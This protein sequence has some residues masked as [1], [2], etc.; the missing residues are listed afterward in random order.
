MKTNRMKN[1]LFILLLANVLFAQA[2]DFLTTPGSNPRLFSAENT[3]KLSIRYDSLIFNFDTLGLP[4]IDDFSSDHLPKAFNELDF[5]AAKDSTYFRYYIGASPIQDSL[6]YSLDSTF[7]YQ[8]GTTG[9]TISIQTTNVIFLSENDFNQYPPTSKFTTAFQPYTVF[10]TIGGGS[11]TVFINTIIRQ[12]SITFF[13]FPV[14]TNA[15]YIDRKAYLNQSFSQQAPTIGMITFDGLNEFGEPYLTDINQTQ[16]ADFLTSVPIDLG[17]ISNP[18][19]VYFSFFYQAKGIAIDGPEKGDS[20]VLEFYNPDTRRWAKAWATDYVDS[21]GQVD[22]FLYAIVP[23][24]PAFQ[25]KGFQFR[26]KAYAQVSGAYDNWHVD[27]IYL[28]ENRDSID[29]IANDLGYIGPP[30]RLLKDYSVMPWWHFKSNPSGYQADSVFTRIRNFRNQNLNVYYRLRLLDTAANSNYLVT[31]GSN[32]FLGIQNL[33][34]L[35]LGY[36][37]DYDYIPDSI[38]GAGRLDAIYNLDLRPSPT[39]P[40]QLVTSNDTIKTGIELQN[41]Y[42]YDDGTAEA[43][44]GINAVLGSEGYVSY[45]SQKFEIPFPD[46]I[47]GVFIYFLPNNPDIRNQKF[48]VMVWNNLN[49]GSIIYEQPVTSDPIFTPMNGFVPYMLDSNIEVNQIFYIGIKAI[50]QNSMHIGYD[51]NFNNRDKINWS[52]DGNNWN[53]P[54]SRI[55]DG[56]LM[57]RPIFRKKRF[58]VGIDENKL[59]NRVNRLDIYPNPAHDVA[60]LNVNKERRIKEINIYDISSRLVK[61]LLERYVLNTSEFEGGI[62]FINVTLDNGEILT[63]KLLITK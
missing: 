43:G 1:C 39:D 28:D 38:N 63:K 20:L 26:F 51:L 17:T 15:W 11:D 55:L 42:A 44:Y 36:E 32:D 41:Y 2:Q 61:S 24:S 35:N 22:S 53:E 34:T 37:V 57:I 10:D 18:G 13:E 47:G 14:D 59:P 23:V 27:Y 4:F 19:R 49:S 3:E 56:T 52:F 8:I 58:E 21:T 45:I 30:S 46:T 16:V 50:G 25:K 60:Y 54:S 7:V 9:D 62:Y 12:D 6:P 5:A 48:R 40:G 33:N 31:P 29:F